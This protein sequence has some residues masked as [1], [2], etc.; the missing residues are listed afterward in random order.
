[1]MAK[2]NKNL[3]FP[4]SKAAWAKV[5]VGFTKG[6]L[7]DLVEEMARN[8]YGVIWNETHKEF[9]PFDVEKGCELMEFWH[10]PDGCGLADFKKAIL[11]THEKMIEY[12]REEQ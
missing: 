2:D 1:M 11:A 7:F 4:D 5:T 6:E 3:P 9:R 10:D 8:G 12:E